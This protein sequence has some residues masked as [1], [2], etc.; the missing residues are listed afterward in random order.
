V[1]WCDEIQVNNTERFDHLTHN[2]P[3]DGQLGMRQASGRTS[4]SVALLP[5]TLSACLWTGTAGE[6]AGTHRWLGVRRRRAALIALARIVRWPKRA[7]GHQKLSGPPETTWTWSHSKVCSCS[8]SCTLALD[9]LQCHYS[10][11]TVEKGRAL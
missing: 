8:A 10:I 11:I 1:A 9:N 6:E 3:G 5:G 4:W 2:D 7:A